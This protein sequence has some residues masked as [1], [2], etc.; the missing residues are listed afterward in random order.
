MINSSGIIQ[1]N[2][3]ASDFIRKQRKFNKI[4]KILTKEEERAMI[5]GY[6]S[7]K[8]V[9][10]KFTFNGD[11]E[12]DFE[13]TGNKDELIEKLIMHNLQAVTKISTK[14]CQDTR[15]Y[16]NMYAKGLYG[17]TRA[18]NSFHPFKL[19]VKKTKVNLQDTDVP[20]D[21]DLVFYR[22]DGKP[23]YVLRKHFDKE[24]NFDFVERYDIQ[25]DENGNPTFV[26]FNTFAQFWIFK[27]VVDEFYSKSI[28]I[29]NN[30]TSLDEIIRIHNEQ[31]KNMT[32]ENYLSDIVSPEI[33]PVHTVSDEIASYEMSSIYESIH[34]YIDTSDNI[35]SLEKSVLE[36]TFYGGTSNI[37]K[38]S[39][40]LKL[41]QQDIIEAQ[42][43]AL[44]KLKDFLYEEYGIESLSDVI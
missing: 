34:D 41:P 1:N 22:E 36:N 39:S 43:S 32:L 25:Y 37:K 26:K 17:L 21:K 33:E 35:S 38:L 24:G 9:D 3:T 27:Y 7:L 11:F 10:G 14:H 19:I 42:T 6:A 15:D 31:S 23:S 29:D 5:E 18:A 16:D 20:S 2:R 30:S 8:T 40:V 28:Q 12:C 44:L 13:W 4:Y